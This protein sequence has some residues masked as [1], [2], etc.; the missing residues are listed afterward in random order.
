MNL[1]YAMGLVFGLAVGLG[2]VAL[3]FKKKVLD[4]TFDE[5]QEL[6]RGKAYRYGFQAIGVSVILDGILDVTV[7]EWCDTLTG[8]F[9][10]LCIGLTVFA[11][12]CLLNDAYMSLKENPRKGMTLCLLA[13]LMNLAIGWANAAHGTVVVDGKLSTGAVNLIV[14]VMSLVIL[15]VYIINYA[16]R[17]RETE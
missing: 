2:V 1:E 11:V 9:I 15:A 5:R 12:T 13:G 3:L 16:L 7:G 4:M 10:C 14:G 17:E 8:N 6:A